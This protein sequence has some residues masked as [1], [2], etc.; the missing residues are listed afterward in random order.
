MK[1]IKNKTK[2]IKIIYRGETFKLQRSFFF[3]NKVLIWLIFQAP[4]CSREEKIDWLNTLPSMTTEQKDKL[5][6]ILKAEEVKLELNEN[7]YKDGLNKIKKDPNY[8]EEQVDKKQKELL[9]K[10]DTIDEEYK[11]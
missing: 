9:E 7:D 3:Y 10:F 8:S 2:K 5:Y 1:K 4:S 6:N 11:V